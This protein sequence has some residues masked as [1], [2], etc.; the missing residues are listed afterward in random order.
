MAEGNKSTSRS[1]VVNY[2]YLVAT[3][4]RV[5]IENKSSALMQSLENQL[6]PESLGLLWFV[7]GITFFFQNNYQ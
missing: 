4:N 6:D 3:R 2:M 7:K 1:E 5:G